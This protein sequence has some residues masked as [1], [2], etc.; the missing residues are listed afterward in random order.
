M[1]TKEPAISHP[2][3]ELVEEGS[4][5]RLS[6]RQFLR[7]LFETAPAAALLATHPALADASALQHEWP[8]EKEE[9]PRHDPIIIELDEDRYLIDPD[10]EYDD[11]P[12]F[13]QY[14]NVGEMD[15]QQ[16]IEF[17]LEHFDSDPFDVVAKELE[18]DVDELYELEELDPAHV[19]ILDAHYS[20]WLDEPMED[21]GFYENA[22]HSEYWVGIELLEQ[23]GYEHG[24]GLGLRLI[25][26][27][28]PGSSFCG[29]RYDGD[30]DVLNAQLYQFGIN[31][32]LAKS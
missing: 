29:V 26:G 28:C 6:R 1:T 5:R 3:T 10:F 25:E 13:A 16:R 24:A 18:L 32:R 21:L 23:L 20:S 22:L 11:L 2:T 9:L 7:I 17:Y 30:P 27:D 12:T 14:Y 19:H 8:K 31:L 15:D 4:T